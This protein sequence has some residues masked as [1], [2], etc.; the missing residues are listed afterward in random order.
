MFFVKLMC[1]RWGGGNVEWHGHADARDLVA[2][3]Y[4]RMQMESEEI[5]R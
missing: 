4:F 5:G 3:V 2:A 1:R